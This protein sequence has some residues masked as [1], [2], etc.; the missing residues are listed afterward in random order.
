[1]AVTAADRW[2]PWAEAAIA[3]GT[4]VVDT[5]VAVEL[6]LSVVVVVVVNMEARSAQRGRQHRHRRRIHHHRTK[7]RNNIRKE[8]FLLLRKMIISYAK[9]GKRN[10][11]HSN[12]TYI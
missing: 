6:E 11:I 1:M 9:Q 5:W 4:V 12:Y 10:L 3:A 7:R 8:D 2:D